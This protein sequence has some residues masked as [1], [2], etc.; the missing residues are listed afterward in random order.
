MSSK[1]SK[2]ASDS[3]R[4]FTVAGSD[5]GDVGGVYNGKNPGVAARKAAS[6][7]HRKTDK[8]KFKFILRETTNGSSKKSK[9]Y[10]ATIEKLRTPEVRTLTKPDGTSVT[11]TATKKVHI[12]SC[13]Q[14]EMESVRTP[15]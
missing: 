14:G 9:F 2:S 12:K 5:S 6:V 11:V 15:N 4:T 1:K 3:H 10:E 8:V 7:L 13:H